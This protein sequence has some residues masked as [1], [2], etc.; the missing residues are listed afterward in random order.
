MAKAIEGAKK[1]FL[2]DHTV[3]YFI[4]TDL[5]SDPD[6]IRQKMAEAYLRTGEAKA[7]VTRFRA[8]AL[9]EAL[10]TSV[11]TRHAHYRTAAFTSSPHFTVRTTVTRHRAAALIVTSLQLAAGTAGR[12]RFAV[13]H[14]APVALTSRHH[15]AR[16]VAVLLVVPELAARDMNGFARSATLVLVITAAAAG[17]R[18]VPLPGPTLRIVAARFT[19]QA[20]SARV[21]Q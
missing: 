14:S 13:L 9:S 19:W 4:W 21:Y 5:P 12:Y 15:D 10:D 1:F 17:S 18:G 3:D 11:R 2:P 8:A 6:I 7:S 20:A 16:P